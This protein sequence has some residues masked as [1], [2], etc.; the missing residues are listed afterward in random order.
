MAVVDVR[1]SEIGDVYRL[2]ANLRAGDAAEVAALGLNP[3]AALRTAY[4]DA[5]LRRSYF[6]DG[7]LAAMSGLCGALLADIG[8]PYLLTTPVA[9]RVPLAFVR[10][11]RAA[12]AEMLSCRM[13][14]EGRVDASYGRAV[15]LLEVLGFTLSEPRPC[16]PNGA[17]FRVYS[18]VRSQS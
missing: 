4:R 17:L 16:G 7:E 11:A 1:H 12:V 2:A 14:L 10:C 3:A 6:V 15:R 13:R 18:V 5:I 9:E 8:E